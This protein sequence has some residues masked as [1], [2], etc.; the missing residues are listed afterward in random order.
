MRDPVEA[1]LLNGAVEPFDM[2]LVIFLPDAA[3]PVEHALLR[4]P[5]CEPSRELTPVIGLDHRE[6]ERCRFLCT[7]SECGT[8]VHADHFNYLRICPA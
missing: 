7:S 6:M 1:F 3:M 5:V 8:V 4:E 2:R